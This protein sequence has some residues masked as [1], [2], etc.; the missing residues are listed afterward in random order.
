MV[1]MTVCKEVIFMDNS[2]VPAEQHMLCPHLLLGKLQTVR[3]STVGTS[4]RH[5][6]IEI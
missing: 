2:D 4:L 6:K 5:R 1:P 3:S